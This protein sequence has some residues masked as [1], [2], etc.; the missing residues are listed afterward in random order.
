MSDIEHDAPAAD[1][2][3]DVDP[4]II[5]PVADGLADARA[6]ILERI[7]DH[8]VFD[9]WSPAA[10]AAAAAEAGVSAETAR[11]AFPRGVDA[12][13]GFHLRGDRKLAEA[14]AQE[15]L[16]GMGMTD[17]ITRAVRLRLEIAEPD[18]ETVRRAASLFAL[19]VNAGNGAKM[20]WNTADTIWTALG[21]GSE[22]LNWYTKRATLSGVISSVTL[23][24]LGDESEGRADTWAH[25]DR[26][27]ADVMR[28]EKAKAAVRRN[29]LGKIA[30]GGFDR[31]T[32]GVRAPRRAGA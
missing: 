14:L 13:M 1:P 2:I 23:Y 26:R 11:L 29:P 28:I 15:P 10:I 31:L 3:G 18:R 7:A 16:G 8:V 21:D 9:G 30:M 20:V 27:I 6:A 32:R 25:L 4:E 22:D 12:A 17:R 5:T 19:P 24:W